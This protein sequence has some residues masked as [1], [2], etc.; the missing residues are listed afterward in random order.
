M[1]ILENH[2]HPVL[3]SGLPTQIHSPQSARSYF[4]DQ[5]MAFYNHKDL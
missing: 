2:K 4:H 1:Q 3:F 5:Y